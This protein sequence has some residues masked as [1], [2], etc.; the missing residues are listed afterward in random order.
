[1]A[2]VPLPLYP[3][4]GGRAKNLPGARYPPLLILIFLRRSLPL[5][6]SP[7]LPA[8]PS[9]SRFA[10][11]AQSA[12]WGDLRLLPRDI[13]GDRSPGRCFAAG[14]RRDRNAKV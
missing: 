14:S 3:E 6:L 2:A 9:A 7:L 10:L 1:M 12:R 5:P 4:R 11:R 8:S 13:S